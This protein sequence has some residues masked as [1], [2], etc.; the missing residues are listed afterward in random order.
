MYEVPRTSVHLA[1]FVKMKITFTI[2]NG[3]NEQTSK[4]HL[5]FIFANSTKKKTNK[6]FDHKK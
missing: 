2:I 5:T 3:Q 6:H 4:L 1:W